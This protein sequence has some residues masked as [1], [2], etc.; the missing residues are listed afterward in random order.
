MLVST[1]HHRHVRRILRHYTGQARVELAE[2]QRLRHNI[3]N[4][5]GGPASADAETHASAAKNALIADVR[6]ADPALSGERNAS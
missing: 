6:T 2:A 1:L 3:R 4:V 5:P